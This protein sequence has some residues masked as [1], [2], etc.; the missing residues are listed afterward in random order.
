MMNKV[1]SFTE[2]PIDH[3]QRHDKSSFV[4][5]PT[6]TS[7]FSVDDDHPFVSWINLFV[8]HLKN[9]PKFMSTIGTSPNWELQ[10]RSVIAI[11][12]L[13]DITYRANET[14]MIKDFLFACLYLHK[15]L[16]VSATV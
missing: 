7:H 4:E 1:L 10:L 14:D 8:S 3:C 16:D 6:Y 13:A 2:V 5:F 11:Q 9:T 15:S 12:G